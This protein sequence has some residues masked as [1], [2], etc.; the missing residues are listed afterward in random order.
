MCI[1]FY[2]PCHPLTGFLI[3]HH[4][5]MAEFSND[6]SDDEDFKGSG[7]WKIAAYGRE[8]DEENSGYGDLKAE[9]SLRILGN[10][11]LLPGEVKT[12]GDF[13]SDDITFSEPR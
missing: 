3:S 8:N 9:A 10:L 13:K 12:E 6:L 4:T 5:V 11:D 7:D 1:I 2:F